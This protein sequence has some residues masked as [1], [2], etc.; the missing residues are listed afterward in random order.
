MKTIFLSLALVF[1]SAVSLTAATPA[2]VP[3]SQEVTA[4]TDYVIVECSNASELGTIRQ[5]IANLTSPKHIIAFHNSNTFVVRLD[6]EHNT[7]EI[8]QKFEQLGNVNVSVTDAAGAAQ[9]GA[10][11]ID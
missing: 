6:A 1:L 10:Q 7:Q 11:N 4:G 5:G 2:Q 3:T 9:Y 8:V